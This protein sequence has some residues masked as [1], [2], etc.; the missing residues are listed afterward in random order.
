MFC[1]VIENI[2]TIV[3]NVAVIR[4]QIVTAPWYSD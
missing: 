4:M 2:E 1:S 3:E